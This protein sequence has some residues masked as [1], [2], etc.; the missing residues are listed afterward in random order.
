MWQFTPSPRGAFGSQRLD[1][2]S[3]SLFDGSS[4]AAS[5]GVGG[6]NGLPHR[7]MS[8]LHHVTNLTS[9]VHKRRIH[10]RWWLL[11]VN[12]IVPGCL[13]PQVYSLSWDKVVI[14]TVV[15]CKSPELK[16]QVND[17]Y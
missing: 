4:P 10:Q 17:Q 2:E 6:S 5:A 13:S 14:N 7:P 3:R 8:L 16:V 1:S 11:R 15:K 12:S 9:F